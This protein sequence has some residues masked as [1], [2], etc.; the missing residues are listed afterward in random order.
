MYLSFKNNIARLYDNNSVNV[1]QMFN[2]FNKKEMRNKED[3]LT[4]ARQYFAIIFDCMPMFFDM[5]VDASEIKTNT[6]YSFEIHEST[7]ALNGI[8]DITVKTPYKDE[9]IT[10][11]F[12]EGIAEFEYTFLHAGQYVFLLNNE[13]YVEGQKFLALIEDSDENNERAAMNNNFQVVVI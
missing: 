4:W 9:V 13:F 5:H 10:V 12:I 1:L 8:Y 11:N 3:A 2:P 7:T 6:K